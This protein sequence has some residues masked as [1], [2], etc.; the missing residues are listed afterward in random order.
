MDS[1]EMNKDEGLVPKVKSGLVYQAKNYMLW[2][3]LYS[4]VL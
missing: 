1:E 3:S 2:A 4:G